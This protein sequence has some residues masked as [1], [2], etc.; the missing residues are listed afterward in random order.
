[1]LRGVTLLLESLR[2]PQEELPY[3]SIIHKL[4]E[5]PSSPRS[6]E[7]IREGI[8]EKKEG[9]PLV[10]VQHPVDPKA[11]AMGL[12]MEANRYLE[13]GL[14]RCQQWELV[15]DLYF[16]AGAKFAEAGLHEDA[17]AA[18]ANSAGMCKVMATEHETVTANSFAVDSLK[19]VD[20]FATVTL[21][22][23]QSESYRRLSLDQQAAKCEKDAA[24]L[25][26][27][28]GNYEQALAHYQS[29][30]ELY[31]HAN[32]V[33]QTLQSKCLERVRQIMVH[34][35]MYTEA[36]VLYEEAAAFSPKGLSPTFHYFC[37]T[38]C[39]IAASSGEHFG[40]GIARAKRKF[41][42]FQDEDGGLQRGRENV[43]LRTIFNA[44]DKPALSLA[45]EAVAIY[46]KSI[47]VKQDIAVLE[48][49]A[50]CKKN[51]YDY[52]LPFM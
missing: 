14:H 35:H 19:V 8:E 9:G 28:L 12:I 46:T 34:L 32:G 24:E 21:L 11:Q 43:V 17:A 6:S 10:A 26:V 39:L 13:G 7:R 31:G 20:P 5:G 45:D 2:L 4:L 42:E 41:G 15:K 37:A 40:A 38:L 50:Q 25:C 33:A 22:R 1:M 29:A 23:E 30:V 44:F 49:L 47:G 16:H 51:L 27:H 52:L 3:L 48:L 36:A 18:Y